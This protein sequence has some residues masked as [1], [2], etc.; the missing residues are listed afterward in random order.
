MEF[1]H[2]DADVGAVIVL[3]AIDLALPTVCD[4]GAYVAEF[5]CCLE[6]ACGCV[7]VLV[8][9]AEA[10]DDGIADELVEETSVSDDGVAGFRV[11]RDEICAGDIGVWGFADEAGE[12]AEVG[13]EDDDFL[14]DAG[15]HDLIG[16]CVFLDEA[17]HFPEVEAPQEVGFQGVVL[18]SAFLNGRDSVGTF[19]LVDGGADI[20][21][22]R[23]FEMGDADVEMFF[24]ELIEGVFVEGFDG[25]L[26][27]EHGAA[28]CDEFFNAGSVG[29]VEKEHEF[30]R[31]IGGAIGL[32]EGEVFPLDGGDDLVVGVA[33][34]HFEV[35][36]IGFGRDDEDVGVRVLETE[37]QFASDPDFFGASFA[38]VFE[39]EERAAEFFDHEAHLDARCFGVFGG[40]RTHLSVCG[41]ARRCALGWEGHHTGLGAF[42][43]LLCGGGWGWDGETGC[44]CDDPM[45]GFLGFTSFGD[46]DVLHHENGDDAMLWVD[47]AVGSEG[48]AVAHATD[49]HGG[50]WAL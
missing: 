9:H 13:D 19:G 33:E 3:F 23:R 2:G 39:A 49:G 36:G 18:V 6:G 17:T 4:G 5:C 22:H 42:L 43:R 14:V 10:S 44:G 47:P 27:G 35:V 48:A 37:W 1:P 25:D 16:A 8:W 45:E 7:S 28:G 31:M 24:G 29:G 40:D 12:R 26:W 46:E 41:G 34:I 11:E 15:T 21:E 38:C 50:A 32:E 30:A 20:G